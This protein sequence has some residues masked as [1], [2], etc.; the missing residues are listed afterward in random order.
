MKKIAVN[1]VVIIKRIG[2]GGEKGLT[3]Y[4]KTYIL[5]LTGIESKIAIGC[6]LAG[7]SM[8]WFS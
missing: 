2:V 8:S 4:K 7:S 6:W 1:A 3:P 5:F